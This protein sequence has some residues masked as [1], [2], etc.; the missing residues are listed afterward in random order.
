MC[1]PKP[2]ATSI[3]PISSRN[4][5]TSIRTD[6]YRSI[7][8]AST[9]DAASITTIAPT[10]AAIMIRISSTVADRGN[11]AVEREDDVE[12][13]DLDDGAE[14]PCPASGDRFCLDT[15]HLQMDLAC[16]LEQQERAAAQ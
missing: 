16:T 2:S 5:S 15:V 7:K 8:P 9:F 6:G 4:E 11:H 1:T 3:I 12:Q 14:E 10:I 13:R